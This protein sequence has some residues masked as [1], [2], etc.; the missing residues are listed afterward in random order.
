M[1]SFLLVVYCFISFHHWQQLACSTQTAAY[2]LIRVLHSE[3][4]IISG[5]RPSVIF[6][7]TECEA[8]NGEIFTSSARPLTLFFSARSVTS[9]EGCA[10]RGLALFVNSCHFWLHF[11]LCGREFSLQ[12]DI[13]L[14]GFTLLSNNKSINT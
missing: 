9:I 8:K 1:D 12:I 5:V 13:E 10:E 3:L 7:R 4:N 6:P 11:V 2:L 14:T